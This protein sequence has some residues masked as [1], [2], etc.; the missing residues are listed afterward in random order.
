MITE[1]SKITG[2][3]IDAILGRSRKKNIA[4]HRAVYWRLLHLMGFSYPQIA[5]LNERKTH[6]TIMSA[7]KM[8]ENALSF[9]IGEIKEINEKTKHLKN[10]YMCQLEQNVKLVPPSGKLGDMQN[11]TLEAYF[12]RCEVC[13]GEGWFYISDWAQKFK[14]DSN[15]PNYELCSC[16]KGTGKIKAV[17]TIEWLPYGDVKEVKSDE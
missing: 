17:V 7:V 6:A 16:C 9:G 8:I 5:K 11:K 2:V 3:P 15:D 10:K 12:Q 13:N 1:F 4:I 14:K